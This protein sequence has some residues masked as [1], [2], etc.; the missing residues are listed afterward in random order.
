VAPVLLVAAGGVVGALARAGAGAALPHEPGTWSWS[1][2]LVN[3]FG[4]AA[5]VL[6]VGGGPSRQ[7]RLL[8]GTGLLGGF[9]TFSAFTVDAAVLVEAGSPVLAVAYVLVGVVTLLA[10]A[11]AGLALSRAVRR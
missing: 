7:V 3:A 11:V 6:L 2:L 9:T 4:A 1:T 5:L 8:V 10:G